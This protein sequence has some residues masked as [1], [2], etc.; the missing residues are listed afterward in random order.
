M[1]I[2]Y[3]GG[4]RSGRGWGNGKKKK[5][6]AEEAEEERKVTKRRTPGAQQEWL[7]HKQCWSLTVKR[8][9]L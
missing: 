9:S 4:A 6:N 8:A 7:C 5:L 3:Q 1:N 2:S